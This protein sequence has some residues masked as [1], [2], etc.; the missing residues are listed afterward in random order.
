M[1]ISYKLKT[2]NSSNFTQASLIYED[3][4]NIY[5]SGDMLVTKIEKNNMEEIKIIGEYDYFIDQAK[6]SMNEQV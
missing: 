5:L 1:L 4:E 3:A 6:E 2:E